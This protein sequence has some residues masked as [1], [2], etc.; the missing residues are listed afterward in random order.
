MLHKLRVAGFVFLL[1][2]TA[3][4]VVVTDS[5]PSKTA[6]RE[7]DVGKAE[8][9][10]AEIRMSAGDLHVRGGATRLMSGSLRYSERTGP[11]AVR[12]DV[13]GS[14]GLLIVESPKTDASIGKRVDDWNLRIGSTVP[15][16][17]Y[18]SLGAGDADLDVSTLPLQFV[19]VKMD[20]GDMRL[21][22]A[23]KYT[24]DVTA[25]VNGG[26]GDTRITLPRNVGAV[27]NAKIGIGGIQTNGLTKRGGAYYNDAYADG[28]PAVRL[29]VHGGVG[30]ITLDVEK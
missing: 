4:N 17:L 1:F 14:R 5:G 27:V 15:L 9:V 19:E 28:K 16:E 26:A 10:R 23:G 20:A 6:E 7:I 11:P 13:T 30:D 3:C 12:Y 22:L 29:E 8:S 2:A 21:N 24:T 18:L 25:L